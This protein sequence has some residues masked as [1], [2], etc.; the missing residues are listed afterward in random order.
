MRKIT[1]MCRSVLTGTLAM[2]IISSTAVLPLSA[3][4]AE[5]ADSGSPSVCGIPGEAGIGFDTEGSIVLIENTEKTDNADITASSADLTVSETTETT[6]YKPVNT[7]MAEENGYRYYITGGNAVIDS[8]TGDETDVTVPGMLGGAA[9]SEIGYAAFAGNQTIV[10]VKLPESVKRINHDAF[11]GCTAL[12]HVELP[13]GIISIQDG[14][15]SGCES[16][17]RIVI[18]EGISRIEDHVFRGCKSLASIDLSSDIDYIGK[19][20]FAG[21]ISMTSFSIPESVTAIGN[22]AFSGSGLETLTVPD[23]VTSMGYAVFADCAAL[24][25][26]VLP[27]YITKLRSGSEKG[28]FSGCSSLE[29]VTFPENLTEIGDMAFASCSSLK[30]LSLPETVTVI[31][32]DLFKD[33]EKLENAGIPQSVTRIENGMFSGCV[34]LPSV[35]LHDGIESIG[36][37][38]FEGC[39][40]LTGLEIPE[41]VAVIGDTCFFR[42]GSLTEMEIPD[43]VTSLGAAALAGCER[44]EKVTLPDGI[45]A[46]GSVKDL[47]LFTGDPALKEVKLPASLKD[48]GAYTFRNCVSLTGIALPEGVSGIGVSAFEGCLSLRE[49]TIPDGVVK[50]SEKAF[51]GCTAMTAAILPKNFDEAG[52]CAFENCGS[53]TAL[54]SKAGF[55]KFGENTFTG[56]SKLNDERATVF[57]NNSPVVNVSSAASIVGG[58]ANFSIKYDLN[59]WICSGLADAGNANVRFEIPLPAGLA[60]IDSSVTTDSAD[61]KVTFIGNNSDMFSLS[62]PEGTLR[63]SAKI[64]AYN[65]KDYTIAPRIRFESRNYGW[66]QKLPRM[67][68]TVPKITISSQNTVSDL[69]CEVYGI[70]EPDRKVKLYVD[71]VLAGSVTSNPYTGKYV[72]EIA[73][74][75]KDSSD[76]YSIYAECG[77]NKTAEISV[78]YSSFRP[79]IKKVELIYCTH[80]PTNI[81][82]YMETLDITGVFTRG[83]RPVIQFYPKGNMRFRIEVDHAEK[84]Q[85]VMVKSTKGSEIKYLCAEYDEKEGAFLTSPDEY[86]DESNHNYVPG[87][88]NFVMIEKTTNRIDDAAVEKVLDALE[89][90]KIDR[91]V[92]IIDDTSCICSIRNNEGE[93]VT[94][95]YYNVPEQIEVNGESVTANTLAESA[96]DYGFENTG[97][98]IVNNGESYTLYTRTT[99]PDSQSASSGTAYDNSVLNTVNSAYSTVRANQYEPGDYRVYSQ[100]M[101]PDNRNTN[102]VLL[103]TAA[104][105]KPAARGTGLTGNGFRYSGSSFSGGSYISYGGSNNNINNGNDSGNNNNGNS[106]GSNNNNN[107]S[108][109]S[110]P[111]DFSDPFGS[112][113][114]YGGKIADTCITL[115]ELDYE[116]DPLGTYNGSLVE[117][118]S[119]V[120]S[121]YSAF[122]YAVSGYQ[123]MNDYM[124]AQQRY[125][126]DIQNHQSNSSRDQY[127]RQLAETRRNSSIFM[128]LSGIAV[129]ELP[130]LGDAYSFMLGG[131]SDNLDSLFDAA[132]RHYDPLW[133]I[134][135]YMGWD[136][137]DENGEGEDGKGEDGDGFRNEY[138]DD[139]KVNTVIDPSGIV[140]EGVKSKT[141]SGAVV[142]CYVFNEDTG[143]WEIW[144]AEDYDQQNP[145]ITDEAG[146]YAWD[147]PEGRYYVTCEKEGY[148]PVTSEEFNVA[149]PKYDLDFNLLNPA[150]PAVKGYTL[151]DNAI[152]VE[153]TK[154]MDITTVNTDSVSLNGVSGDITVEPQLY[155]DDDRYTD[156]FIITGDFSNALRL[157]LTVSS[158]AADY[159]GAA[160]REY[161][162]EIDNLYADLILDAD[163]VE[164]LTEETYQITGNKE[165]ALYVSDDPEIAS[166]DENGLVTAVS[167]GTATITATDIAGKEA[168]L[169]VSVEKKLVI[170]DETAAKLE[171]Q[172]L[173]DYRFRVGV[174]AD[175]AECKVVDN[176]CIVE[177]KDKDGNI[178]DVYTL[179][180][181]T[182]IGTDSKGETVNL[183]QTGNNSLD[184]LLWGIAALILMVAGLFAVKASGVTFRKRKMDE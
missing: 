44:L 113:Q 86:F 62:K 71:G 140:Y 111:Y 127:Y 29:K 167:A 10:S 135:E 28:M 49:I 85:T 9:V 58:V 142:T 16:L 90:D 132:A 39:A 94:D 95:C 176:K 61:N 53:L 13:D 33:C 22:L 118:V 56:C 181:D 93:H 161:T 99:Q 182:R 41:S 68:L 45:E 31:G 101:I 27:K 106:S 80:A 116:M 98:K 165:I 35:H 51:S 121:L 34:S 92:D 112:L 73:L 180:P 6:V 55:F 79:S 20:A 109:V 50:L 48:L 158:S 131:I 155:A 91:D 157:T 144:N 18:P 177:L 134:I 117:N 138:P 122:N 24:K 153:F 36:S 164:L 137:E 169:T 168:A 141:V 14:A 84:I 154:V 82:D 120:R 143:A 43:S 32:T 75:E 46:F 105:E 126:Q 2:A 77:V 12:T 160:L 166:V 119:N 63:F 47:G 89:F 149:P 152:T 175:S 170:D 76:P 25:E 173:W 150:A 3:H 7:S 133:D 107:G 102:A 88:L 136:D 21:C 52:N 54:G 17:S 162:A 128:S 64:E 37:N 4:A 23:T 174:K 19:S 124:D 83:E 172:S 72:A 130:V 114:N 96:A 5:T 156:S 184:T 183:P 38:A 108:T 179:D 42:C 67:S 151:S 171:K 100:L 125:E 145:L 178:L 11:N 104:A 40:A 66:C 74:P 59:D 15:F 123:F 159:T 139:G 26:I 163:S 146:S 78:V 129:S 110:N 97:K 60:L 103:V 30:R 148:D 69:N 1:K 87:S 81:N 115:G 65:D 57:R 147:V 70:A 8:Y